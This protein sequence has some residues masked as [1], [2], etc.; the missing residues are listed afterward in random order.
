MGNLLNKLSGSTRRVTFGL[1]LIQLFKAFLS[2]FTVIVS[3]AYFGTSLG[4]DVWLL[5]LSIVAILGAIIFGPVF[6]IFRAKFVMFK[7]KES[8]EKALKAAGSLCIYMLIISAVIIIVAEIV[9]AFLGKIFAPAYTNEQHYFLMIMIRLIAPTMLFSIIISI[10]TGV[11]N[12]YNVFYVPE[13]MNI[14]SSVLN[15]V[16]ILIFAPTIGIYSLVLSGYLSNVILIIVLLIVIR[17]SNIQLF[18]NINLE[19]KYTLEFFKFALPLYFNYI[20]AQILLAAERIISTFLGIGSISVLDYARKFVSIPINVIQ[21]TVNVVLTPTL[22]KIYIK[23]GERNFILEMNKFLDMILLV[24]L[25]LITLF[26]VC[27]V[28][29]VRVFLLR[30]AFDPKFVEPTAHALLWF[31]FGIVSIIFY[32]TNAQALVAQGRI[33]ITA[34]ISGALGFFVLTINLLFYKKYGIQVLAFS[35][36]LAHFIVGVIFYF[37][38]SFKESKLLLKEFIRKMAILFVVLVLSLGIYHVILKVLNSDKLL[39]KSLITICITGLFS[40]L[41]E[42]SLIYILGFKE[43]DLITKSIRAYVYNKSD[44]NIS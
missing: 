43:K 30:G 36:S 11:L 22:A 13:F 40:V 29:I 14:F 32:S 31:G 16:I 41:I 12:V 9:P 33:K 39:L 26:I 18:H 35:W 6:E 42:L 5:S 24:T 8:E 44:R 10:L 28:E 4:R 21:N 27:P 20:V 2:F 25:P 3:S 7:E 23:E 34:I 1:S 19:I 15:M 17:K 37:V 38:I